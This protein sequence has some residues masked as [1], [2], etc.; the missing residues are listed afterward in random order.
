MK[1]QGNEIVADAGMAL[2]RVNTD[3]YFGRCTLME[4]ET[5][6]N[7]EEI[8]IEEYKLIEKEKEAEYGNAEV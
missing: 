3:S 8:T 2:H 4:G 7:F 1:I 5:E 6:A